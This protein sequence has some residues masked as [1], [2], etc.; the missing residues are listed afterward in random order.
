MAA[1]ISMLYHG[2]HSNHLQ[3]PIM[4]P[5]A[6]SVYYFGFYLLL[7]GLA[8]FFFPNQIIGMVGIAPTSEV[9]IHLVGALIFILGVFFTYTAKKDAR[10]FFFISMFGRGIFTVAILSLVIFKSAPLGLLLFAFIDGIGLLWTLV[11]YKRSQILWTVP[12]SN[13]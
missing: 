13:R 4:S 10:P 9:W 12:D 2:S 6:R 8:L 5:I 1:F 3:I 11:A 7:A